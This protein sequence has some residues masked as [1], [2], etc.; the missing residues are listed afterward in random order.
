MVD[1]QLIDKYETGGRLLRTS[2]IGLGKDD[3]LWIPPPSP[4]L[5]SWSIQ[6]IVL[7]LMDADL[8]WSERMKSII[9]EDNPQIIGYDESKYAAGLFYDRQDASRAV[10]LF[11]LNR[12][13]FT[14][15]LRKLPQSAFTRTGNHSERGPITLAQSVQYMVE[16]VDHHIQFINKKRNKMG[17]PLKD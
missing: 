9:A 8:I 14:I 4:D 2:I 17:K 7:H 11:D 16:H 15:V 5:G 13:Q 10:E 3:L 1:T 12:R 6:Q